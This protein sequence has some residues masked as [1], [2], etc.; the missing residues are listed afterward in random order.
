MAPAWPNDGQILGVR[1]FRTVGSKNQE[2][3]SSENSRDHR[4]AE[5]HFYGAPNVS[6]RTYALGLMD[7]GR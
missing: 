1:A 2:L 6:Q 3:I 7:Y 5:N 4:L